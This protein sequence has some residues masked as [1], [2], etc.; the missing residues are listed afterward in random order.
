MGLTENFNRST[1]DHY[2]PGTPYFTLSPKI[3]KLKPEDLV[4][5]ISVPSRLITALH[6]GPTIRADKYIYIRKLVKRI[7]YRFLCRPHEGLD[8]LFTSTQER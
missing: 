6:V 8:K 4:P 3:H 2:K 1:L 7:S 5:G